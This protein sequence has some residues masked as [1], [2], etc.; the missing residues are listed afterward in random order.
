MKR[1]ECDYE[2]CPKVY[3]SSFNLKRHIEI[4]HLGIKKFKCSE[5]GKFMSSKQNLIDHQHIHT[6]AKPYICEVQGCGIAFRQLSQYY[7]H[8][9]LHNV[10]ATQVNRV[11]YVSESIIEELTRRIPEKLNMVSQEYRKNGLEAPEMCDLPP[12]AHQSELGLLPS[13]QEKF[14]MALI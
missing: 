12:I 6:G 1:L 4:V 2:G 5:C 14:G 13:I 7:L 3:C 8:R 10:V 9:Q 11:N